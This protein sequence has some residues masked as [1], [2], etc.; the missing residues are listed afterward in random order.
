[1]T[2]LGAVPMTA[3]ART[4][5]RVI[6]IDVEA[7]TLKTL[8]IICGAGLLISLACD[9]TYGLDLSAAFF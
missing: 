3:L 2:D 5:S 1:M 8:L 6:G 4:L 7:E 9:L